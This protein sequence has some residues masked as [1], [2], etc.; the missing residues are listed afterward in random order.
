[1]FDYIFPLILGFWIM[2]P[3]SNPLRYNSLVNVTDKNS[4]PT[5]RKTDHL[6]KD[7]LV[8]AI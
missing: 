7:Q 8:N 1:M 6:Y 3:T 4:L 5:S 2:F